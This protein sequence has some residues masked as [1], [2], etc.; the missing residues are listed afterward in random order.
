LIEY[1]LKA[2]QGLGTKGGLS[3]ETRDGIL[4]S[5]VPPLSFRKAQR[6]REKKGIEDKGTPPPPLR[7]NLCL[8]IA[9]KMTFVPSP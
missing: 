8:V 3:R 9:S 5:M 4:L 1:I 7:R 6:G 2:W